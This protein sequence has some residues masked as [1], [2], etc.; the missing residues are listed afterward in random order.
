MP[1]KHIR[2]FLSLV[3]ISVLLMTYQ[4]QVGALKPF[5]IFSTPLNY[6]NQ[7]ITFVNETIGEAVRVIS[8]NEEELK[9]LREEVR[10]L[11]L[12]KQR[13]EET[14]LENRRLL[15]LLDLKEREDRYLTDARVIGKGHDRWSSTFVIDKGTSD[16]VV[17]DMAVVTSDGL[18]GKILD[19]QRSFSTVLLVGDRRFSA[20]VRLLESRTE[21]VLSG[22]GRKKCV[23]K[24]I[25]TD[26]EVQEGEVLVTSGLDGLFPRGI[27]VGYVSSVLTDPE[28]LFH[29]IEATP[30]VDTKKVEEVVILRQ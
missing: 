9:G 18:L 27:R 20:G 5:R 8:L 12:Q 17:K 3:A 19:A 10:L 22:A 4:S 25:P 23:L 2:V 15:G 7:S 24:Y 29:Q 14:E 6:I 11:R 30:F 1:R 16:L 28:R 26:Q 21:G 13:L